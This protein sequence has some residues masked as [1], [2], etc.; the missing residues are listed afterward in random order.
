MAKGSKKTKE[1]DGYRQARADLAEKGP[2]RLYLL[3]GEEDYLL[4]DFLERLRQRCVEPG[5]E[6]FNHRVL[7]GPAVELSRLEEAVN[8]LPFF[9]EHSLVEI[10]DF[11]FN[12]CQDAAAERLK[13]ILADIPASCT[14]AFAVSPE[15]E[16]D[17]RRAAVKTVKKLGR[18]VYFAPQEDD[19]LHKW[20]VRRFAALG[21]TVGRR[22]TEHLIFLSGQRMN[23]LIPEIEKVAHYAAGEAVTLSD[24]DAVA[25]HI[26]EADAF[27]MTDALG[28]RDYEAGAAILQE[29]LQMRTEPPVKLLAAIGGQIR[30]LY[31]ARLAREEGLGKRWLMEVT[32]TRFDFLADKLL[33]SAAAFDRAAL[34]KA[35]RACAACDHAMKSTGVDDTALLCQLYGELAAEGGHG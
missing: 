18:S 29:L 17:G 15:Y 4:E 19:V 28:R 16:L 22:E 13:A 23:A 14:V 31:A 21:K 26:P 2:E 10:R 24:I 9:A 8:A 12:K 3:Y 33:Q 7:R 11:D 25:H 20:I 30:N 1:A 6:E 5:T 27:R 32:G 34:E 35:V